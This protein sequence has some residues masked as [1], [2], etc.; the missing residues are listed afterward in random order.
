MNVLENMKPL[1]RSI[2]K[3]FVKN[4]F[5]W[6]VLYPFIKA[7]NFLQYQRSVA[8]KNVFSQQLNKEIV[9]LLKTPVVKH[10]PFKGLKY[11]DFQSHGSAIFPKILGSYEQE[12]HPVLERICSKSYSV[13]LDIGS[14]EGYY[15]VGLALRFADTPV[16]AYD[17]NEAANAACAT[18]ALL[19]NVSEKVIIEN[20]CT[21]KTLT[22]FPFEGRGLII[23]DCEG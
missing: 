7:S 22:E 11:P 13:I 6:K 5:A 17:I 15:A 3:R 2:S 21:P 1:I 14:A 10:G 12:L 19:N 16:Y 23:S 4:N 8:I 9:E 18:M 20:G